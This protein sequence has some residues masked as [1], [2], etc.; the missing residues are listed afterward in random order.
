[1]Q[2]YR[3]AHATALVASGVDILS[4]RHSN[5]I[6]AI[7]LH[8][9]R[10]ARNKRLEN[11]KLKHLLVERD[12]KNPDKLIYTRKLQ[13][14]NGPKSYGI[15]VCKSMD[16]IQSLLKWLENIRHGLGTK[17]DISV[18]VKSS[19][20]NADK[21]ITLCEVCNDGML[22]KM[23][24]ILMSKTRQIHLGLLVIQVLI[25]NQKVE[26]FIKIINGIQYH[27]KKC[28]QDVHSVPIRLK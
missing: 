18:E 28:H 8:F 27:C 6:F 9:Y 15:L 2:W 16:M 24:I 3:D 20:Y 7:H 10:Y 26:Y 14:G 25:Q 1:M 4:R 5:F 11:I 17:K 22:Q 13:D 23:Y 19:K 12:P 21:I